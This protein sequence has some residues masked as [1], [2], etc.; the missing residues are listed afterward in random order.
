[1]REHILGSYRFVKSENTFFIESCRGT[2]LRAD[3]SNVDDDIP[4]VSYWVLQ[5]SGEMFSDYS[6]LWNYICVWLKDV[7]D[8]LWPSERSDEYFDF[9]QKEFGVVNG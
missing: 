8:L 6:Q 2:I 9:V 3:K 4:L 7:R 5:C 1:M